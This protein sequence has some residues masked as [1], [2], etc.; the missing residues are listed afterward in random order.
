MQA[1]SLSKPSITDQAIR[2]V[3][4][5]LQS[6]WLTQGKKVIEFE[7]ILK[8]HIG[9][10]HALAVSSATS[11]LYMALLSLG[12]GIG[13][14]VIVPSFT[15]VAS[16]NIIEQCGATPV[17]VDSRLDD[18]N[19]DLAHL[20]SRVTEKTKAI[21]VVHVFGQPF[22][23]PALKLSVPD[24]IFIIEDAA[25]ALGA[26]MNGHYCGT[27]GHM[28]VFSFHPRKSITTGEGGMVVTNHIPLAEHVS[29]LR[30]HGQKEDHRS[31]K[32]YHLLDCPIVGF[33][34]RMTDFQ[35]ALGLVQMKEL[36]ALIEER[37]QLANN[38]TKELQ[39]IEWLRPQTISAKTTQHAWQAYVCYVDPEKAPMSRNDIMEVLQKKGI[40]TRPGTH[41]VHMLSFYKEKYKIQEDDLPGAKACYQNTMAIPFYNQMKKED[42]SYVTEVLKNI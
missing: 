36:S 39:S 26:S 8:K 13:D 7:D 25:C 5:V 37:Q 2:E 21:L 14:E 31:Y 34:Y 40:E 17:F 23:V 30:N 11:G 18:F 27:M 6:G 38:Y 29:M 9:A 22:D 4:E 33:N 28:G 41:A 16:A 12:V 20:L 32:P 35:A 15:W 24:N 10:A 19:A 1:V 3:V 42:M